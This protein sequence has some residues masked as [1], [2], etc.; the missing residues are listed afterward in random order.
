[1]SDKRVFTYT[2]NSGEAQAP[3]ILEDYIHEYR[4]VQLEPIVVGVGYIQATLSTRQEV[5]DGEASWITWP[6]GSI[7]SVTQDTISPAV[8]AIRAY[9]T[10]GTL[11]LNVRLV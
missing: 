10:S 11:L 9:R 1:M 6:A 2:Y 7:S 8:T 4:G 5:E 3:I